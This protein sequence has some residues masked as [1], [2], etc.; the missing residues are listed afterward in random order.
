MNPFAIITEHFPLGTLSSFLHSSG[1]ALDWGLRIKIA[2]DIAEGTH[3]LHTATPPIVHR[4]LTPFNVMV[5]NH[6]VG[7][8]SADSLFRWCRQ[9]Q[10]TR[11]L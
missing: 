10:T 5:R 8:L 3:F 6:L 2:T 1:D 7:C 9:N 4:H 11:L